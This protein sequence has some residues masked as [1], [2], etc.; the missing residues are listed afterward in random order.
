MR[1][2]N[3]LRSVALTAAVAIT[4]VSGSAFAGQT[5]E[6][7]TK[8]PD[9]KEMNVFYPPIVKVQPGETVDWIAKDKGHNVEFIKGSIPEGATPTTSTATAD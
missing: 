7:L 5:V 3:F 9:T 2:A 1:F 6:M 4:A 8:H